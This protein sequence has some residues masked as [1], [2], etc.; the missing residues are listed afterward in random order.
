[1]A[2]NK[3]VILGNGV[4]LGYAPAGP[5][6]EPNEDIGVMRALHGLSIY[7]SS[8]NDFIPQILEEC[9]TNQRTSYVR[10]ERKNKM[11]SDSLHE[12]VITPMG[13]KNRVLGD[14]GGE[15]RLLIL[16]YG[17]V[18]HRVFEVLDKKPELLYKV[19]TLELNE[20]WPI[21]LMD[22]L[23]HLDNETIILC[24]EEQSQSGSIM[25]AIAARLGNQN[26]I[27]GMHLP[28]KYIFENGTQ[29]ELLNRNGLSGCDIEQ[30][31]MELLK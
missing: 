11:I 26:R 2:G 7:S 19:R 22:I 4:G 21:P 12:R 3:I 14:K 31:I 13:Q 16:T 10:L 30:K 24:V 20:I 18:S 28:D 1:M 23:P 17:Y 15:K 25:E 29:D 5:A 6:H 27:Y 8:S 9:L